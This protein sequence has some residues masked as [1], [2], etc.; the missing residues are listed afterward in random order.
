MS[1][2]TSSAGSLDIAD[3]SEAQQK[4]LQTFITVTDQDPIAAIPILQRWEWNAEIAISRFFDGEPSSDPL[5]EARAA[6]SVP[7]PTSRQVANLQYE[8]LLAANSTPASPS[9]GRSQDYVVRRIDTSSNAVAAYRPPFLL[10]A[11]F[12]PFNLLF[13]LFSTVLSP[14]SFLLPSFVSRT[15]RNLILDSRPSRRQ[16]PP[17]DTARRFIRE[18][19]ETYS[20][21]PPLPW[22]ETGFN[23]TLD[24]CK[25][26]SKFLLAVLV[27][28]SHDDT[29]SWIRDTLLS[30]QFYQFLQT[31][32]DELVLWG[33]SVQ[34]AEGYQVSSSLNCTKFPFAALICQA[35]EASG[36]LS[37]QIREM[38]VVMRAAGPMSANELVA[39]LGS[40]VTAQRV[41]LSAARA[42]RAEQQAHRSLR[43]EQDSAYERSLAQDRERA[44]RRREEEEA[45]AAAEKRAQQALLEKEM[46]EQRRQQWRRWRSSRLASEPVT[47]QNVVRLSI[48]LANGVRVIRK[49]SADSP[50][51]ELYAFVECHDVPTLEGDD[52]ATTSPPLDYEHDYKF[53]LVSPI[54]RNVIDLTQGGSIGERVRGGGNLIVEELDDEDE[55][56]APDE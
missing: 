11:L 52:Q 12:T 20:P 32:H 7:T 43:Q 10:S 48:R 19:E 31:H 4:A 51:E 45:K 5:T 53:R 42:Q 28:P 39:K 30:S 46:K 1:N 50:L 49:F 44:R 34:D 55:V 14:L 6:Q 41:Q 9:T 36:T 23:L 22:V 27:S 24:N 47:S 18:F 56:E 2:S 15:F 3:L 25:K 26:D 38:V 40:V 21:N 17:A 37:S 35:T 29:H 13:R 54:P 8:S 33:G 16:L